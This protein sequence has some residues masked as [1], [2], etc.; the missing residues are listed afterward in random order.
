MSS[1]MAPDSEKIESSEIRAQI[2]KMHMEEMAKQIKQDEMLDKVVVEL[3]KRNVYLNEFQQFPKLVNGASGIDFRHYSAHSSG[4][5]VTKACFEYYALRLAQAED[6]IFSHPDKYMRAK[7][8]YTET[9]KKSKIVVNNMDSVLGAPGLIW[10]LG[11]IV[12]RE[13]G[14]YYLEDG[15]YAVKV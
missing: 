14:A 12:L 11:L 2:E 9:E 8:H 3:N 13:D 15:T 5:D 7:L 10:V 6:R 4:T 1:L